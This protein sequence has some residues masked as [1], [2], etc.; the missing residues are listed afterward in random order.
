MIA[1]L[2]DKLRELAALDSKREYRFAPVLTELAAL[3]AQYDCELPADFRAF[4]TQIGNGGAGPDQGLL[5]FCARHPEDFTDYEAL[6]LPF[7]YTSAF[8]PTHLLYEGTS[9]GPDDDREPTDEEQARLDANRDRYLDAFDRA[10][11]LYLTDA[12]CNTHGLL[13]VSGPSRGQVWYEDVAS[14]VGYLPELTE[15]G[16]R[17]TFASWY[18]AWL[19]RSLA[20]LR[21]T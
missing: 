5:G 3:E 10:G 16:A 4:I 6:G 8:N 13:I 7:R 17:H 19:D 12:G 15:L 14:G 2:R 20:A 1:A 9:L 21:S 18:E 11:A